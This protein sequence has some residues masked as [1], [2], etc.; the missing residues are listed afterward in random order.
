MKILLTGAHGFVGGNLQKAL[1]DTG[2]FVHCACRNNIKTEKQNQS[3][4]EIIIGDISKSTDWADALDGVDVIIHLAARV[5]VMRDL[6]S[7]PLEEFRAVNTLGTEKLARDSVRAGV[8]RFIFIS[9]IKVNGEE[10]NN[11]PF[12]EKGEPSPVDPYAVSK[13]EAEKAL[14]RISQKTGLEVVIIR[15]PLVYGPM[16][17]GNFLTLLK[18]I[19]KGIPLPLGL[20]DN[21]RSLIGIENLADLIIHCIDHPYASGETFL[22]SDGEDLST[23]NLIR[24]IAKAFGR[25]PHLFP[26]PPKILQMAANVVGK[27]DVVQRLLGSLQVDSS[28]AECLLDWVPP[29]SVDEGIE[30]SIRWYREEY[31]KK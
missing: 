7:D 21:R 15:S 27:G 1:V 5:H 14:Y 22:A 4:R 12:T 11:L 26:F 18:L 30:H 3:V 31:L 29:V 19:D 28:K 23:P 9:T 17:K 6:A 16:V 8:K 25:K 13:W 10:T 20:V 2:Y 24:R